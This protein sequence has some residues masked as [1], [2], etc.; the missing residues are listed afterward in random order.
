VVIESSRTPCWRTPMRPLLDE[1]LPY[2]LKNVFQGTESTRWPRWVE[3]SEQWA[4][5]WQSQR[6]VS[7][8]P[9]K[10]LPEFLAGRCGRSE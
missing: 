7:G 5:C 4:L 2:C 9:Y 3:E 1:S 8:F 10:R 6:P